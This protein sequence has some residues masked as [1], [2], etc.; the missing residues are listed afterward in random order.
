MFSHPK[1]WPPFISTAA[2]QV[3]QGIT[4]LYIVGIA[5]DVCVT[6]TTRDAVLYGYEVGLDSMERVEHETVF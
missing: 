6:Y 3:R 1:L 4:K 2:G 5:T